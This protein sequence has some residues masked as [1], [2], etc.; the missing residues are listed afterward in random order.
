MQNTADQIDADLRRIL[1]DVLGLNQARID[2][3]GPDSGLFGH[4]PELDSMAVANLLGEMEERLG[5]VI[6]D[7]D[8][9]GELLDSFGSLLS[10]VRSKQGIAG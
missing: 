5:I 9:D 4:M 1:A 3:L 10:F 7:A 2:E 8:I 6:D